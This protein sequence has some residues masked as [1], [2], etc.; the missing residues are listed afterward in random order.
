[1]FIKS[2]SHKEAII[3]SGVSEK[4]AQLPRPESARPRTVNGRG[5][6]AV[7]LRL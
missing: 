3:D 7:A 1:M 6:G 5:G 2:M 4:I